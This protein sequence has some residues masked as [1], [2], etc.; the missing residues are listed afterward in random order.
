[1]SR[2]ADDGRLLIDV[3]AKLADPTI[4]VPGLDAVRIVGSMVTGADL[5][6]DRHF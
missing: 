1:V 6:P 4:A 2:E 3:I 5:L